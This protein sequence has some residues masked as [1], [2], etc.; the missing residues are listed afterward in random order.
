MANKKLT[1]APEAQAALD[2]LTRT[3]GGSLPARLSIYWMRPVA[4][5]GPVQ[6]PDPTTATGQFEL[7]VSDLAEGRLEE[8][9]LAHPALG[10][11]RSYRVLVFVPRAD[12]TYPQRPNRTF[13]LSYVDPVE[14]ALA[15][16]ASRAAQAAASVAAVNNAADAVLDAAGRAA[17]QVSSS[18]PDV[19]DKLTASLSQFTSTLGNAMSQFNRF[20]QTPL[21][22]PGAAP[23][24][25]VYNLPPAPSPYGYP[26]AGYPPNGYS[27]A[28]P[29]PGYGYPP[30][31][32]PQSSAS[33]KM[34]EALITMLT[35]Q[36]Q[37]PQTDPNVLAMLQQQHQLLQQ[38]VTRQVAAPVVSG[39]S[40]ELLAMQQR[41]DAAERAAAEARIKFEA[42]RR[43]LELKSQMLEM[44]RKIELAATGK[45]DAQ[46]EFAKLQIQQQAETSRLMQAMTER[47]ATQANEFNRELREVMAQPGPDQATQVSQMA[48]AMG[49][50][51][52]LAMSSMSQMM[53]IGMMGGGGE[54]GA[55]KPAWAEPAERMIGI[56]AGLGQSIMSSG[57]PQA[58]LEQ[59]PPQF[60][61][62]QIPPEP[63]AQPALSAPTAAPALPPAPP[64]PPPDEFVRRARQLAT[65]AD[66]IGAI[67]T[68]EAGFGVHPQ[69][70]LGGDKIR[71]VATLLDDVQWPES[72]TAEAIE[73]AYVAVYGD[74]VREHLARLV[75]EERARQASSNEEAQDQQQFDA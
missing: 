14:N 42:D 21:P 71:T 11:S 65:G 6:I 73:G 46:I 45:P 30:P 17:A 74:G 62:A 68:L 52:N 69:L 40:P 32:P 61:V 43:E 2:E 66:F 34:A 47:M 38:L 7:P 12:G 19:A 23:S 58:E 10:G 3:Y 48:K 22:T 8:W 28:P 20:G 39:P 53:R 63:Q 67:R 49:E 41:I 37:A 56:L 70:V 31:P 15:V 64:P 57:Q 51:T 75:A 50:V 25:G 59:Q 18:Q 16:E 55:K 5:G 1:I 72:T 4:E 36:R 35:Q 33:D 9:I 44:Q 60:Q 13:P 24:A 54:G 29:P 27:Y 26:P